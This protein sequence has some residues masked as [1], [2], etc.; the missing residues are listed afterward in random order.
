[1]CAVGVVEA[2]AQERDHFGWLAP[3]ASLGTTHC[4]RLISAAMASTCHSSD[5]LP[6]PVMPDLDAYSRDA[7]WLCESCR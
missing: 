4:P 3:P 2:V 5:I 7:V 1:M 6:L